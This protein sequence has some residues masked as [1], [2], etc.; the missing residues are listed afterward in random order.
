MYIYNVTIQLA[1][2]IHEDWLQWMKTKHIPE[3]MATGC[4][5]DFRFVRVLEMDETEGPTY[6]TQYFANN[7][8]D[9]DRYIEHY[10]TALRKDALDVWGNQFVGFRSLMQV[11]N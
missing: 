2:S 11:V 7:K 9:Y 3:V 4:F 5:T 10:S 1:W 6:A 8:E